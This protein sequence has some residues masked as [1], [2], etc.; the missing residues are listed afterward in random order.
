MEA[1]IQAI[2][3]TAGVIMGVWGFVKVIRDIKK[4]NDDEVEKRNRWDKA[5]KRVEENA[6]KWDKGLAD[7]Y[8]ERKAIVDRYDDRLDEMDGK[9]QQLYAMVVLLLKAQDA[10][11]EEQVKN[12]ANGEIKK[13]HTELNNFIFSEIGK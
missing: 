6:D 1:Y 13:M 12:G 3:T 10:T 11:F 5:A 4:T 2:V 9:I 8:A 7:T